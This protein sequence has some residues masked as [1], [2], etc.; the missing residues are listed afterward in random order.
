MGISKLYKYGT[1]LY[2]KA[3]IAFKFRHNWAYEQEF[4]LWIFPIYYGQS[5][6]GL[7]AICLLFSC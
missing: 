3:E 5:L 7:I 4:V 1:D 6:D 2:N